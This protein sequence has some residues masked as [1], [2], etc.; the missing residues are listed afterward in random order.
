MKV[1]V[2]K[3]KHYQ[4]KNIL[5]KLDHIW[6]TSEIISESLTHGKFN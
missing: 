5:I 2:T 6:K 1:T 3:E 4:L